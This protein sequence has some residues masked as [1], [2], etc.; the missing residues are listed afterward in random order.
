MNVDHLL[1]AAESLR[2]LA[3]QLQALPDR[4]SGPQHAAF[5]LIEKA[6]EL[7]GYSR[8]AIEAKIERGIWLEGR[9]WI[10]APDG[11]RQISMRGYEAW[12]QRGK[13]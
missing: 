7:T 13:V 11:R 8:R 2:A 12:V 6:A 3:G 1:A 4:P 5:V 10:R 9:E